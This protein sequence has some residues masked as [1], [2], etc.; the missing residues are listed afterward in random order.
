MIS[1]I[2]W[3]FVAF[4]VVGSVISYIG[5]ARRG[6]H[7]QSGFKKAMLSDGEDPAHSGESQASFEW[8]AQ[9]VYA[10][11]NGHERLEYLR[12]KMRL[13]RAEKNPQARQARYF[14]CADLVHEIR[15]SADL[16]EEN[17]GELT[18]HFDEALRKYKEY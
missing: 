14:A 3:L 7:T 12:A 2:L 4:A 18:V 6:T 15:A 16:T 5:E 17:R 1:I 11:K 13:A 9:N 10:L 8:N